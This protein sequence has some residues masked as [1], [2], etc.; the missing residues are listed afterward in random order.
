[1][2]SLVE[3]ASVVLER[4]KMWKVYGQK[5]GRK[6]GNQKSLLVILAKVCL[7]YSFLLV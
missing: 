6:T 3:I 2:Q 4:I 5:D 7:N 1:M